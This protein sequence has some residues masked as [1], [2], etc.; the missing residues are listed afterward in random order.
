M[1]LARTQSLTQP[2]RRTRKAKRRRKTSTTSLG[3]GRGARSLMG[4]GNIRTAGFPKKL[5]S[6]LRYVQQDDVNAGIGSVDVKVFSAVG[7]YDPYTTGVGNQ[8]RGFDQLMTAYDHYRVTKSKITV[9]FYN[10]GAVPV[11]VGINLRDSP[12][13]A[14]SLIGYAEQGLC[15]YDML[16]LTTIGQTPLTLSLNYDS[17]KF[18]DRTYD[19]H[20]GR[21]SATANPAEDV[22]FHVWCAAIGSTDPGNV[23][24]V[25]TIDF[26]AEFTEPAPLPA[27]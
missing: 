8:P 22:N 4:L 12:S 26:E 25:I 10:D 15:R 23:R 14:S 7:L 21:G 20:Q 19:D 1:S 9:S 18:F 6:R 16:G 5:K 17:K 11:M 27:S 24:L 3:L 13:V 2:M